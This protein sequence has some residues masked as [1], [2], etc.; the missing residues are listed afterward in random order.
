MTKYKP[1]D[2]ETSRGFAVRRQPAWWKEAMG[3]NF[4][5]VGGTFWNRPTFWNS[6]LEYRLLPLDWNCP[7][8]GLIG[9]NQQIK[10]H[11]F[12]HYL[13]QWWSSLLRHACITQ[14]GWVTFSRARCS[15][16]AVWYFSSV[17][18]QGRTANIFLDILIQTTWL[19]H[20]MQSHRV[21]KDKDVYS[22]KFEIMFR[23]CLIVVCLLFSVAH[24]VFR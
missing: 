5:S 15:V 13:K 22:F 7:E 10:Q 4:Y 19:D 18:R 9:F 17:N 12:S 1:R 14:P 3:V 23:Q 20:V 8:I 24:H 2:F 21:V 11:W 6:F 16:R